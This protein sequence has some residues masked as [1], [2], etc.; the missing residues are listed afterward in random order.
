MSR[1]RRHRNLL[2]PWL[3]L[4]GGLILLPFLLSDA[5]GATADLVLVMPLLHVIGITLIW[6]R[7]GRPKGWW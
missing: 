4:P 7:W 3:L 6:N 1:R 2:T 5:A